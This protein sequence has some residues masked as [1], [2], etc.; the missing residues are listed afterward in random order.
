MNELHHLTFLYNFGPS[1]GTLVRTG[2]N[3][4][5]RKSLFYMAP[6]AAFGVYAN[7]TMGDGNGITVVCFLW[8]WCFWKL[9]LQVWVFI[10][11]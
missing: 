2:S 8:R 7:K 10:V 6:E 3:N 1:S 4:R 5:A 9:D 11:V